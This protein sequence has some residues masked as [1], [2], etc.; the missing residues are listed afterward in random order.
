MIDTICL[1]IPKNQ[2]L[3]VDRSDNDK[4]KLLSDTDQYQKFVKNPSKELKDSGLY[5][6]RLTGYKRKWRDDN[7]I[8]IEFSIPKIIYNNNLDEVCENDFSKIIS[9]LQSRL[10]DMGI[11]IKTKHLEKAFVSSVHFSKNIELKDGYTVNYVIGELNK[12]DIRKSFDFARARFI[13]DGQ[14]LYMHTNSHE[15]TIYDKLSD[16]RKD[17]KRAIDKDQTVIQRSLFG[18]IKKDKTLSN[19]IRFEVRLNKRQKLNSLLE[20]IGYSKNLNFEEIFKEDISK[21]ILLDYWN[22]LV[23]QKNL[24]LFTIQTSNK[25]ILRSVYKSNPNIKPSRAIYLT[26]L[27]M[28]A[29]DGNGML[30][31]RNILEQNSVSRTWSRIKKD[32]KDMSDTLPQNMIRGWIKQIDQELENYKPLN[33][34]D[35]EEV[36]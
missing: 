5:Y 3:T 2:I 6:P 11:L 27:F 7:N 30:E 28:L 24:G 19:V 35:Y 25:D 17:Q 36:K 26:G 23:K 9:T 16:M 31:L 15:F 32:L 13:N 29:K 4:W 33:I 12:I 8:K 20:K 18:E 1:L 22:T 10:D 34:K 21:K 14:S